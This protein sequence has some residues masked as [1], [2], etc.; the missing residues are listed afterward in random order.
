MLTM[1]AFL[2]ETLLAWSPSVSTV[3]VYKHLLIPI[4]MSCWKSDWQQVFNDKPTV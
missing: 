3:L 2:V 4:K 1:L